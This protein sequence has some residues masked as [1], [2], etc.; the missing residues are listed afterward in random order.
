VTTHPRGF[1]FVVPDR[2]LEDAKGDIFTAAATE[3]AMHGDR[4]W[5]IERV[6]DGRVE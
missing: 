1:G 5:P 2:P 4:V 3:S 6:S